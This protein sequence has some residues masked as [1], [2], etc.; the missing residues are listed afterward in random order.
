MDP[1]PG[2]GNV[3]V[4]D[5]NENAHAKYR[6]EAKSAEEYI[7]I[8]DE[9]LYGNDWYFTADWY[10]K[11]IPGFEDEV[12]EIF[13]KFSNSNIVE[14]TNASTLQPKSDTSQ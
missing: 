7:Y 10:R 1:K 11:I 9:L 5:A 4:I 14:D 6:K 3:D 12:Y 8:P 2:D 13:E